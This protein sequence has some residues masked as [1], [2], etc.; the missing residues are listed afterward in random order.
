MVCLVW[1]AML[2]M[3]AGCGFTRTETVVQKELAICPVEE[4]KLSCEDMPERGS[5]FSELLNAWNKAVVVNSNCQIAVETWMKTYKKCR[6][7]L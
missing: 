4:V 2:L 1:V 5:T 6:K 7:I 3:L